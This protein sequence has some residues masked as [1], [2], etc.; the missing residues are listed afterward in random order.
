MTATTTTAMEVDEAPKTP[1]QQSLFWAGK[2]AFLLPIQVQ[3][4]EQMS[5]SRRD[6]N[7]SRAAR[8]VGSSFGEAVCVARPAFPACFPQ[9][10]S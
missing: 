1:S 3:F 2:F 8:K 10:I 4:V 7:E 5:A 9:A 6:E